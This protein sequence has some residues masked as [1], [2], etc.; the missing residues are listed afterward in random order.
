MNGTQSGNLAVTSGPAAEGGVLSGQG[1]VLRLVVE[2]LLYP[3]S[4]DVLYQVMRIAKK[5]KL[6]LVPML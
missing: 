5:I 2:N 4:L 1:P 3:V 6:K